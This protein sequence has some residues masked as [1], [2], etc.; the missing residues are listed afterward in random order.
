MLSLTICCIRYPSYRN[1]DRLSQ[2]IIT[3]LENIKLILI[4]DP[5]QAM[6][7]TPHLFMLYSLSGNIVLGGIS[8]LWDEEIWIED[9]ENWVA[10]YQR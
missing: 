8:S 3:F 2:P 5:S 1:R 10:L 9:D 6:N 7:F 4:D